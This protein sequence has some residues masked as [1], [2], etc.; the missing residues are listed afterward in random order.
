MRGRAARNAENACVRPGQERI[1]SKHQKD[2]LLQL[3]AKSPQKAITLRTTGI[4]LDGTSVT[5]N[6]SDTAVLY[7]HN[8]AVT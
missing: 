6:N 3:W 2:L 8:R 7:G 5:Q 4:S 1:S